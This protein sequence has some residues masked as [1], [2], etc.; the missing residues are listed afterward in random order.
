MYSSTT[1]KT[2]MNLWVSLMGDFFDDSLTAE[3]TYLM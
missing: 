1:F 3:S 2:N